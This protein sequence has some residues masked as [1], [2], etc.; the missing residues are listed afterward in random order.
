[1]KKGIHIGSSEGETIHAYQREYNP[2]DSQKGHL[3]V[4]GSIYGGVLFT[5]VNGR[6][7]KIFLGAAAD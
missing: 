6:V 2:G 5:I 3:V 1:M 4:A 7:S